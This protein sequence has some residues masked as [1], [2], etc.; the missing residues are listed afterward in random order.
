MIRKRLIAAVA[1]VPLLLSLLMLTVILDRKAH[2]Q[3]LATEYPVATCN[4]TGFTAALAAAQTNPG[5]AVV[6][7][8]ICPT[9]ALINLNAVSVITGNVEISGAAR[10]FLRASNNNR[11]FDVQSGASL[12]LSQISLQNGSG[13]NGGAVYV[14]SSGTLITRGALFMNNRAP[15][16]TENGGA[17]YAREGQVSLINTT[18][19]SNTAGSGGG[20]V[21][22]SSGNLHVDNSRFL[23]NT[24]RVGGALYSSAFT[25]TIHASEFISNSALDYGGGVYLSADPLENKSATITSSLFRENR[26]LNQSG[27]VHVIFVNTLVRNSLFFNNQSAFSGGMRIAYANGAVERTTFVSNAATHA[28]GKGGG[29]ETFYADVRIDQSQFISNTATSGGGLAV[30][31]DSADDALASVHN[32]LFVGNYAGSGAGIH[33]FKVGFAINPTAGVLENSTLHNNGSGIAAIAAVSTE[34]VPLALSH[35]TI[36]GSGVGVRAAYSAT[37]S[38][39]N[40]ILANTTDC[41]VGN[42]TAAIDASYTL[43]G[44]PTCGTHGAGMIVNGDPLLG[45]L[46]DNGGALWTR[47]PATGSPAIDSADAASCLVVDQ[48]GVTRPQGS[49]CDMGA[50]ETSAI[51]LPTSTPTATP[52]TSTPIPTVESTETPSATPEETLTP[53]T[54]PSPESS[55]TPNASQTPGASLTPEDP[56]T[57]DETTTPSASLTP[58]ATLDPRDV[59]IQVFLSSVHQ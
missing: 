35:V 25:S 23:A 10:I 57:P 38:I 24:G 9:P 42:S 16:P 52:V 17:I 58:I 5:A 48:R 32:S 19:L 39:V 26:A 13:A 55:Q 8:A 54:P 43:I 14:R 44:D 49:G 21:L 30:T 41:A 59:T 34:K 12:T 47:L 7:F 20:A 11:L 3:P 28:I 2:A 36:S 18:F 33:Y 53:E 15:G 46:Q 6:T 1:I 4:Q 50:V 27:G 56:G 31:V 37:I 51:T 45:A 29:L 22:A 40:S